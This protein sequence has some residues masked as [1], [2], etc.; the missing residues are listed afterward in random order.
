M[1]EEIKGLEDAGGEDIGS[2]K[3]F[4]GCAFGLHHGYPEGYGFEHEPVV[5]AVS[6]ANP[7]LRTQ[8]GHI[9]QFCFG[10]VLHRD[11]REP[12]G[13][14]RKRFPHAPKGVCRQDVDGQGGGEGREML[15]HPNDK[16]R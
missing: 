1:G 16:T 10:L 15:L 4:N 14:A 13:D 9:G 7:G 3:G 11:D 2:E 5:A 8:F 12:A 6:D